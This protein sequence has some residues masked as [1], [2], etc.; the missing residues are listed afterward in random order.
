MTNL[1]FITDGTI[2]RLCAQRNRRAE[3]LRECFNNKISR[4]QDDA[5]AM[6]DY[7]RDMQR[8][9]IDARPELTEAENYLK[10]LLLLVGIMKLEHERRQDGAAQAAE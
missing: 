5:E 7:C 9:G 1:N 8:A 2:E 3:V 6:T 4:I 10:S